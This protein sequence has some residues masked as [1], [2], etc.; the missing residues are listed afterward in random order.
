MP[1]QLAVSKAVC[2]WRHAS[3]HIVS[4]SYCAL[5]LSGSVPSLKPNRART[6][7]TK[8]VSDGSQG[9]PDGQGLKRK[10]LL[11]LLTSQGHSLCV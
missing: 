8:E 4:P 2:T 9:R 10:A 5:L 3:V 1:H 11:T 7:S 6:I